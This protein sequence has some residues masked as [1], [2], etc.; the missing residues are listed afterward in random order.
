MIATMARLARSSVTV[1]GAGS[2]GRRLAYMVCDALV[3]ENKTK[4]N[5]NALTLSG[6]VEG[7]TFT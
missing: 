7:M 6:Q 4:L 2:Q 5:S 3:L 1:V